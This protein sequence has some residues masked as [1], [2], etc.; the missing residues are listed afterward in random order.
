[1]MAGF[2]S[3]SFPN[4]S[5]ERKKKTTGDLQFLQ[6]LGENEAMRGWMDGCLAMSAI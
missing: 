2:F 4:C 5:L 3:S 6:L 1:M